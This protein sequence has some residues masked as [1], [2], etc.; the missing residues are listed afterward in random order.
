MG[1]SPTRRRAIKLVD[2]LFDFSDELTKNVLID[3]LTTAY[4]ETLFIKLQLDVL[5]EKVA[6]DEENRRLDG[7]VMDGPS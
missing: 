2:T 4:N 3:H 6:H 7:R 1:D 5:K